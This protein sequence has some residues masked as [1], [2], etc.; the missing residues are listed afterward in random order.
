M[1]DRLP[2]IIPPG[3]LTTSTDT[4]I[5]PA[6]I[7]KAGDA[8]GWRFVEFFTANINN[9]HTRRA[10]PRP[11]FCCCSS[12]IGDAPGLPAQRKL[13]SATTVS[14]TSCKRSTVSCT[15]ASSIAAAFP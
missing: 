3:A 2:A 1:T 4:Y 5:V 11:T 14:C 9:D 15:S 10:Y 8:V 12:H 7:A 6:L 13:K